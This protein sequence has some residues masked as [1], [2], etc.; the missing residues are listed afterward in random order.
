ML[1]V[2]V[3]K[4]IMSLFFAFLLEDASLFS[5]EARL[6]IINYMSLSWI[7]L[8]VKKC[9]SFLGREPD[10]LYVIYFLFIN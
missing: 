3:S 1:V 2:V 4:N 6:A 10:F 8:Y 9:P 7:I 5:G